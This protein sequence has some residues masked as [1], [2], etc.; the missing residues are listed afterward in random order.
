M[1]IS[2]EQKNRTTLDYLLYVM[3]GAVVATLCFSA[4]L[5]FTF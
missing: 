4:L 5:W 1:P 2:T 3:A